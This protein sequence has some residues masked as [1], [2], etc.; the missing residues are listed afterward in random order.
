MDYPPQAAPLLVPLLLAPRTASEFLCERGFK[1]ATAT[2]AKLRCVGGG[3]AFV[4]FGR[5]VGYR[6]KDLLDWAKNRLSS[7]LH[8]TCC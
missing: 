2:L 5:Y 1:I 8:S 4:R 6:P 3:P 7:P